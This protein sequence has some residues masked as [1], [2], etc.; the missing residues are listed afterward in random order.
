[1]QNIMRVRVGKWWKCIF[2]RSEDLKMKQFPLAAHHGAPDGDTN[3]TL[4]KLNL[5]GRNG[6]KG[7]WKKGNG[8]IKK[9]L[10]SLVLKKD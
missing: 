3:Q 5:W 6:S 1:M 4:N 9:L 8:S 2:Q 10:I 7:K